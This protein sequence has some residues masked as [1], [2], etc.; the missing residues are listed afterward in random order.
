MMR[1]LLRLRDQRGAVA[2]IVS[3]LAVVLFAAA[4]LSVDI[5]SQVN[6]RH[7]LMNQLDA[8]ATAAAYYLDATDG[9]ERA[10]TNAMTYFAKNGR[11]TLDPSEITFWCVV[12]RKLTSD[13][14]AATPA[15]VASYQI[16]SSTQTS[17]VCNPDAASTVTTWLQSDYQSRTRTWDGAT[18]AMTC[19]STLC[20][21]PCALQAS[22]GNDWSPGL[23][24][25]NNQAIT[26]NTI[27]VGA[28]QDVPFEFAPVIG[29]DKGSTG[30]QVAVACKGTCGSVAPNPMNVVIVTDRTASMSNADEDSMIEGIRS[31]L[32][33]M[34][35]SVQYVALGTIGRSAATSR[36]GFTACSSV[37]PPTSVTT[38]RGSVNWTN[39]G[40]ALSTNSSKLWIPLQF[41]STYLSSG[42]LNSGSSLAKALACLEP[43]AY[44]GSGP[45]VS[46]GTYL[47]SP[48]K[49]AARYVLGDKALMDSSGWNVDTLGGSS[50]SGQV[51][52]VIIFET[53]G[54]PQEVYTKSTTD[55]SQNYCG[56]ATDLTSTVTGCGNG[57]DVFSDFQRSTTST[58]SST[59]CP[60][61][62]VPI[63]GGSSCPT[64]YAKSTCGT[65]T[66]TLV[67]SVCWGLSSTVT[68]TCAKVS[69]TTYYYLSAVSTSLCLSRISLSGLLCAT[70]Y[71]KSGSYCYATVSTPVPTCSSG[72]F[73]AQDGTSYGCWV[74]HGAPTT[75]SYAISYVNSTTTTTYTGGQSACANFAGVAAAFKAYSP[76]DLI[77]TVGYNLDNSTLCGDSNYVFD[78]GSGDKVKDVAGVT[79]YLSKVT[80]GGTKLTSSTCVSGGGTSSS[81]YVLLSTC[82]KAV[83]LTYTTTAVVQGGG[84]DKVPDVLAAAAGGQGVT[85]SANGDCSTAEGR[86]A[87]NGDADY[88]F[89]AA[90]GDDMGSIFVTALGQVTGG[91][92][93]IA[94]PK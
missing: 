38:S 90:T 94:L 89:C 9:I 78:G 73:G 42:V 8:A 49:A 65:S 19:S 44:G 50:R 77:V 47:A 76:E 70:G 61:G 33:A 37:A 17:G 6:R 83:T 31:M 34:T 3:A 84:N 60:S 67:G 16:P 22:P 59:T 46:Y 80:S 20:A 26:C 62:A 93:L 5:A 68:P 82:G 53:D 69:G 30:A 57:Y 56:T 40:D 88:F 75:A 87:E 81:P 18:F 86:A 36:T 29:T 52:N 27:R 51:R 45:Q 1:L 64:S 10:A 72:T 39:S 7:L 15:Q 28:S 79:S 32:G 55:A 43:S 66:D 92:K 54:Q 4:A 85:A 25:A 14:V 74:S 48:L 41:S 35:P 71:T 58:S 24:I 12:P 11:G 21:V 91:I 13:G 23:S 2:I 63:S